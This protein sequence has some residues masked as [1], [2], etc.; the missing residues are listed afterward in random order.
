[1]GLAESATDCS[2]GIHKG[3]GLTCHG[4]GGF[5]AACLGPSGSSFFESNAVDSEHPFLFTVYAIESVWLLC[6]VIQTGP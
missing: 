5:S 3:G 1:M 2:S 6:R 4:S